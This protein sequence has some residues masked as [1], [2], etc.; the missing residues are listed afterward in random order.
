MA[1][2]F[3][4]HAQFVKVDQELGL[5]FGWGIVCAERG[6]PYFDVQG[7]HIPEQSMLEA[8]ADFMKS[9]RHSTDMH[10]ATEGVDGER[11]PVPDGDVVLAFP[12]TA[13]IAKALEIET[14]KTGLLL[15]IRPS[16]AVLQKFKDGDY[17]GFSI[18]G[19]RVVDE[20]V[21]A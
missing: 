15:A 1:G 13:D 12:L 2:R 7:D 19:Q 8:A 10:A 11:V 3:T 16:Q 20:Q 21:S 14:N 9:A 17:T 6:E 18:G 4:Q 5:V